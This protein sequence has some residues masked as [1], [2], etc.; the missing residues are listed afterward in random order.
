MF[1]TD[2]H[3]YTLHPIPDKIIDPIFVKYGLTD[4]KID[5]NNIMSIFIEENVPF[6]DKNLVTFI[7]TEASESHELLDIKFNGWRNC[8]NLVNMLKYFEGSLTHFGVGVNVVE[9]HI[10]HFSMFDEDMDENMPPEWEYDTE[11][12]DYNVS[13]RYFPMSVS[14]FNSVLSVVDFPPQAINFLRYS[15]F[16]SRV[17]FIYDLKEDKL[18]SYAKEYFAFDK[19]IIYNFT[20]NKVFRGVEIYTAEQKSHKWYRGGLEIDLKQKLNIEEV[21]F[22][23]YISD[24]DETKTGL[25]ISRKLNIDPRYGDLS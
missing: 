6:V 4:W 12:F 2:D 17:S 11:I 18:I 22:G 13:Q 8:T 24:K 25:V 15:R 3:R 20:G 10:V 19:K 1:R 16:P 5:R 14:H 21:N 7:A 9:D 23:S